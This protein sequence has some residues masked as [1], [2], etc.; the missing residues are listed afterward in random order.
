MHRFPRSNAQNPLVHPALMQCR[1]NV[2]SALIQGLALDQHWIQ[3]TL[4]SASGGKRPPSP[5]KRRRDIMSARSNKQT[6]VRLCVLLLFLAVDRSSS[7][8]LYDGVPSGPHDSPWRG[9]GE[10]AEKKAKKAAREDGT[11]CTATPYY[12]RL[13]QSALHAC[14]MAYLAPG[15]EEELFRAASAARVVEK[16][17]W[18]VV[19][20][21][22]VV[23]CFTR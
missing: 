18:E 21:V 5:Q 10:A 19:G 9:A 20:S 23:V 6:K 3:N 15:G 14:R 22:Q 7:F 13:R 12:G 17:E 4:A 1:T 16:F 11:T 8:P 2:D